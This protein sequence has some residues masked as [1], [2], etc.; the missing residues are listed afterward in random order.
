MKYLSDVGINKAPENGDLDVD[1]DIYSN[2]AKV[3]DTTSVIA[4]ENR[5]GGFYLGTISSST[6]GTTGNKVISGVGFTPKLVRFS[7]LPGPAT[8]SSAIDGHGAMTTSSQYF[9]TTYSGGGNYRKVSET[10]YCIG[11]T[12]NTSSQLLCSYV[13]MNAD[14]FTINVALASSTFDVAFEAY[15]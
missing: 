5:S 9:T 7:V 15:A 10:S 1:G 2:G 14:G 8:T 13:S 4:P 11:W 6:L 3:L 12:N